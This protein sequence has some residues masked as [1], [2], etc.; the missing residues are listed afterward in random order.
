[1]TFSQA[2]VDEDTRSPV[3]VVEEVGRFDVAMKYTS[4]VDVL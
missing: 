4:M 2:E 3:I 1:L